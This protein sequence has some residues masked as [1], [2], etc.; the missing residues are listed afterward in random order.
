MSKNVVTLKSVYPLG[1]AS[2]EGAE[3]PPQK[4]LQ[5]F[6][7]KRCVLAHS[8]GHFGA[9]VTLFHTAQ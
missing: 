1:L 3:P 6:V 5:I 8:N 7:L 4:I 2:M 9:S